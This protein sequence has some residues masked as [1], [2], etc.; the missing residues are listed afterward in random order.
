VSVA[1]VVEVVAALLFGKLVEDAA[2][3][4][5]EFVYCAFRAVVQRQ[6]AMKNASR[7]LGLGVWESVYRFKKLTYTPRHYRIIPARWGDLEIILSDAS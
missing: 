3:E 1:A 7:S 4:F 5:L 6:Q 2:A